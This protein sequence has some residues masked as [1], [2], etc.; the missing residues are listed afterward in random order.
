[1]D[2]VTDSFQ[3]VS[4]RFTIHLCFHAAEKEVA[5]SGSAWKIVFFHHPLY[6]SGAM[7]VQS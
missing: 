5:Q 7:H 3:N 4:N 1:M 6:S 2:D